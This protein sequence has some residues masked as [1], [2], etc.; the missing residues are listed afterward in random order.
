MKSDFGDKF[1]P[2]A[3]PNPGGAAR[4]LNT[5]DTSLAS[6]LA[7]EQQLHRFLYDSFLSATLMHKDS[8]PAIVYAHNRNDVLNEQGVRTVL[9]ELSRIATRH[10]LLVCNL[11]E[12]NTT[13]EVL[14]HL[15]SELARVC[16]S[17]IV[18][19]DLSFNRIVCHSWEKVEPVL[20]QLLAKHVVEYL[21]MSNNYFPPLETLKQDRRL[22]EKFCS[23][24]NRLSLL[25]YDANSFTGDADI[26]YWLRNARV[27]KQQAYGC[28]YI[29]D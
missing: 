17:Q 13:F 14:K 28:K 9:K 5:N 2:N 3:R 16:G 25:S 11:S 18:A 26:D 1:L 29:H 22:S 23:F 6:S 21:D 19:L 10:K 27:F 20:D 15:P 24:G 7:S 12:G 4:A 8:V